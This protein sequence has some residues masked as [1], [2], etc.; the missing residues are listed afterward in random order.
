MLWHLQLKSHA[1]TPHLKFHF[2]LCVLSILFQ[3][4]I[5]AFCQLSHVLSQLLS[6]SDGMIV[7]VRECS[8]QPILLL[9]QNCFGIHGRL[10]AMLAD[11]AVICTV[12]HD[13]KWHKAVILPCCIMHSACYILANLH[14]WYKEMDHHISMWICSIMCR[15]SM[16]PAATPIHILFTYLLA[17]IW[18]LSLAAGLLF[19]ASVH[20][21]MLSLSTFWVLNSFCIADLFHM[22]NA[23]SD[24][25]VC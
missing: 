7:V 10:I 12:A 4:C 22:S 14:Q 19:N 3:L 15:S 2:L 16:D 1:L 13:C 25:S 20:R 18:C 24:W 23:E 21:C 9:N 5:V 6:W 11:Y 8:E 17:L